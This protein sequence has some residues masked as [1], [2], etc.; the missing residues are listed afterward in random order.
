MRTRKLK[1][2]S[3]HVH[4]CSRSQDP[5]TDELTTS[6]TTPQ[7]HTDRTNSDSTRAH[8]L[9][10]RTYSAEG[11]GTS[12]VATWPLLNIEVGSFVSPETVKTVSVIL[13]LLFLLSLQ[14]NVLRLVF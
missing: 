5:S 10:C 9:H 8:I 7:E 14:Q 13:H 12:M 6:D 11:T 1:R 2:T 4:G 3:V